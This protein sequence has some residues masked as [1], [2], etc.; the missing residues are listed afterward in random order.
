MEDSV[1]RDQLTFRGNRHS[2]VKDTFTIHEISLSGRLIKEYV[3]RDG[4]VFAV[5]WRGISQPDLAVLFGSYYQEYL[6]ETSRQ[7]QNQ[8]NSLRM[9]KTKNVTVERHGHMRDIRGKAYLS[10]LLPANI[11]PEEIQ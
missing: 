8:R 1:K 4:I 9:T 3:N 7:N 11:T 5:A 10:R 2:T 6:S